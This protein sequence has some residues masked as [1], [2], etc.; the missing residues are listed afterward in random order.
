MIFPK[1]EADGN[2]SIT[3]PRRDAEG[4][5]MT[6][7]SGNP[8]TQSI[9]T[10]CCHNLGDSTYKWAPNGRHLPGIGEDFVYLQYQWV[11]C[12]LNNVL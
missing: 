7:G 1:P 4:D 10:G 3:A 6:D 11:D 2:A 12:C 9:R 5:I 8:L